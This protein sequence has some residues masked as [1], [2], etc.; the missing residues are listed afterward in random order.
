MPQYAGNTHAMIA[1]FVSRL[2]ECSIL[3]FRKVAI[4]PKTLISNLECGSLER[5]TTYITTESSWLI[6]SEKAALKLT[7][8]LIGGSRNRNSLIFNERH[9]IMFNLHVILDEA[10]ETEKEQWPT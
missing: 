8:L 7:H 4:F 9:C 5:E 2:L 10:V 1:E 6:F 3:V